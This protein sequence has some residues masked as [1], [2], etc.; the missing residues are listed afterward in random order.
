MKRTGTHVDVYRK[1]RGSL[2]KPVDH[3]F[4]AHEMSG[5]D[6]NTQSTVREGRKSQKR[7]DLLNLNTGTPDWELRARGMR[8]PQRF[9]NRN[10]VT[11][12]IEHS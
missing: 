12:G 1:G 10:I 2:W 9:H 4:S 8:V 3:Y 5:G 11:S 7:E 6:L